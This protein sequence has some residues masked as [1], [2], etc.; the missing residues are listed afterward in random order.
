VRRIF[1]LI[2]ALTVV[3]LIA[4]CGGQ[5]AGL[6]S[7]PSGQAVVAAD[8][9]QGVAGVDYDPSML[10]VN[11]KPGARVPSK[12]ASLAPPPGKRASEQP[13]ARVRKHVQYEKLTDAAAV[14]AGVD[15]ER[16]AYIDG[17][18]MAAFRVP[19]GQNAEA[20]RQAIIASLGSEIE[21]VEYARIVHTA[22][23]P[24][25]PDF[26]NGNILQGFQWGQ[27]KVGCEVAWDKTKG[28]PAV[29]IAVCD[30]GVRLTHEELQANVLNP[31]VAFPDDN[32]DVVNADNT[33]EDDVGHGSYI[34][35]IIGAEQ[36][37]SRTI[38]GI[39]P[40]CEVIPIK[41]ANNGS[42]TDY[43][44]AM[45]ISLA[46]ELGAKVINL[47]WGGPQGSSTMQN[48]VDTAYTNGVLLV[49][50]AGNENT[51]ADAY[52]A[53]YEHALCV[54]ATSSLDVRSTFSNYGTYVDIAAPGEWLKSCLSV[55]DT[56][57][58]PYGAGTSYAAP[59]VAAAAGLLWSY[60]PQLTLAEVWDRLVTTTAPTS[61]FSGTNPVG[62]LDIAAALGTIE[63]LSIAPP[64]LNQLVYNGVVFLEPEVTG[65]PDSVEMY[66][67]DQLID[68]KTIAPYIFSFD[69]APINFGVATVDFCTVRG[70]QRTFVTI[71]LLVDNTTGQFPVGEGFED[72]TS[73]SYVSIDLKGFDPSFVRSIRELPGNWTP[74]DLAAAGDGTWIY[75]FSGAAVGSNCLSLS[76]GGRTYGAYELD[77][78]VSKKVN[79]AGTTLPVLTF[80]QHYN[81]EDGGAGNDRGYVYVTSDGVNLA[82][83]R[84]ATGAPVYYT[85]YQPDWGQTELDLSQF[86]GET[87]NIV[88]LFESNAETAGEE[89]GQSAGWWVDNFSLYNS[90]NDGKPHILD[91]LYEP[92]T[93]IGTVPG[94]DTLPFALASTQ[95]VAT[96]SYTLDLAP[97][98][99]PGDNDIHSG[100]IATALF[101]YDLPVPLDVPNQD[102]ALIIEYAD[103]QDVAGDTITIPLT[104]FNK[105]GDFNGDGHLNE[106][107]FP[108]LVAA[109]GEHTG[110]PGFDPLL[111]S[112]GDGWITEAD[113]AA[114]AYNWVEY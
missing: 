23:T 73:K 76:E 44:M 111:D 46:I 85:G 65:Q 1:A 15:I 63:E 80:Y 26:T 110:D 35:G 18:Q 71:D 103:A 49:V 81:I 77:A 8:H 98:G 89:P 62:R 69:T 47:S 61:G 67:N 109:I 12:L 24:N 97:V 55:S 14:C 17:M 38:T 91:A 99:V 42:T 84:T 16:Q 39:A 5:T 72:T 33:V 93:I 9:P 48:M 36:D 68:G 88:L 90:L 107:D 21:S 11:Y 52:P 79:L 87:V 92:G 114:V 70:D 45:G 102:V 3:L 78:L 83:V 108:A 54:G 28:I 56:A 94:I 4:A 40:G 22:Y 58:D 41:I 104:I 64:K 32:L 60:S 20:A 27:R 96:V 19:A 50:A 7:A 101:R 86:I 95:N 34:A 31:Q 112:D 59:F 13:L 106:D 37:N 105:R 66:V 53:K 2:T 113:A 74:E 51:S 30:T 75:C 57:Y 43:Q 6:T 29:R 82:P 10:V 25:D 100:E